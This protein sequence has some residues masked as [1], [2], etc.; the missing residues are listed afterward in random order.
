MGA[1]ADVNPF[2]VP[3]P[4]RPV[5]SDWT[6]PAPWS[7]TSDTEIHQWNGDRWHPRQLLPGELSG[8]CLLAGTLCATRQHCDTTFVDGPE[9][10]L[11]ICDDCGSACEVEQ[12]DPGDAGGVDLAAN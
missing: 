2:I 6:G 9:G 5:P 7:L 10:G 4:S 11:V 12:D 3:V 1:S 8:Y